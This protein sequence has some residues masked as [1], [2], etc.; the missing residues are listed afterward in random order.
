MAYTRTRGNRKIAV[1]NHALVDYQL[2]YYENRRSSNLQLVGSRNEYKW[3]PV[4]STEHENIA[5]LSINLDF[6]LISEN[7]T[8]TSIRMCFW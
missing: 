6:F 4:N 1:M 8:S 7:P 2:R 5:K 3:K